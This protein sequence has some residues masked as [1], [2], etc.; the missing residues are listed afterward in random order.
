VIYIDTDVAVRQPL[1]DLWEMNLHGH[2]VAAVRDPVVPWAGAPLGL[3][4]SELGVPPDSPCFN[5][6]VL[7][8]ETERWRSERIAERALDLLVRQVAPPR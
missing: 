4:W 8:I 3:P 6:G 1:D 2:T 7:V 5:S